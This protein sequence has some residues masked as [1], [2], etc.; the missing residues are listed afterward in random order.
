[1]TGSLTVGVTGAGGYI[2]SRVVAELHADGH[3]VV[4]VDDFSAAQVE[5]VDGQPI[6]ELDVRN[7]DA[8]R[9][10][11]QGVDAVAHLAAISGIPDCTADPERAFDVNV[12]GTE[13]VAWLCREWGIPLTFA[14]SVAALGPPSEFPITADHPR[15]PTNLYG[16]TKA[17]SEDD[18]H[19]LAADAFPAHVLMQANLYGKHRVDGTVVTKDVVTNLFVEQALAGEPLTVHEPGTQA[20]DFVH[21]TDVARA[22]VDSIE[23]LVDADPGARSLVTGSGECLTVNDVAD[24]VSQVAAEERGLDVPVERVENPRGADATLANDFTVDTDAAKEAIGFK[25]G[26]DVASAVREM[27]RE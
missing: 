15:E 7:R 19:H 10:T 14:G 26:T 4:P 6:R 17:M 18:I 16:R 9:E 5:A 11:F 23:T 24:I 21:V 22:Y 1:V 20:F 25:P 27:M 8:L 2:G 12:V 13:N 3:D